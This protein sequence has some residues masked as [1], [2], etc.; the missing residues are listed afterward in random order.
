MIVDVFVTKLGMTQAW[1]KDGRRLAVTKC[2]VFDNHVV[3]TH[4]VSLSQKA[5]PTKS[6]TATI[7]ELGFGEKKTK[8]MKKPLLEKVKKSGFSF[9][10]QHFRG[11]RVVDSSKEE[12][13]VG[14]SIDPLTVLSVGDV[15]SVQGK[16]KGKGFLGGMKRWGFAGGPKTHGQSD[17]ARAVG[18]IGAG[19]TPGRVWL[20]KK[21]PG[22]AGNEMQTVSGLVVLHI[23]QVKKELWLSGTV[24][25]SVQGFLRIRR[26]G[27]NKQI[28]L[29]YQASNIVVPEQ[30]PD[31]NEV[32]VTESKA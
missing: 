26:T 23:D 6:A 1:S 25:G 17:R 7:V 32:D 4:T 31:A 27:E 12:L 21:M 2:S 20:G 15:V 16:T 22:D 29:D 11:V 14:T 13:K 10:V 28:A 19:T 9:G 8:N 5:N 24:P 3:A 30:E 18:S